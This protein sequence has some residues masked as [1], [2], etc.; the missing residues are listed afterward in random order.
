MINSQLTI[1]L[2]DDNRCVAMRLCDMLLELPEVGEVLIGYNYEE[3]KRIFAEHLTDIV[4]LDIHLPGKSGINLLKYFKG[5]GRL[6]GIIM[7]SN[8]ANEYYRK[9]CLAL[10]ADYLIDKTIDLL[11]LPE[12]IIKMKDQCFFGSVPLDNAQ[13]I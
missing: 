10:G 5:T 3:A 2:V 6:C 11:K 13:G 9:R 4:L 7:I 1:L 8:Q 12:L